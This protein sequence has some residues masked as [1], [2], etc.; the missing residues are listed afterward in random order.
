MLLTYVAMATVTKSSYLLVQQV[1]FFATTLQ[2][3]QHVSNVMLNSVLFGNER[4][5]VRT[6][7]RDCPRLD[8]KV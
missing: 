2:V 7:N 6:L 1:S 5:Q 4:A 3:L 8:I